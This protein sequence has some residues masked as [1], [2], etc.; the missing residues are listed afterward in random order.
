MG[1]SHEVPSVC[2]PY[3]ITLFDFPWLYQARPCISRNTGSF[4]TTPQVLSEGQ[5]PVFHC[6]ATG[7]PEPSITWLKDGMDIKTGDAMNSYV[8]TR[9]PGGLDLDI[10]YVRKKEHAGRYSCVAKNKFGEQRHEILLAVEGTV[11]IQILYTIECWIWS[12]SI[13]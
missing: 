13:E 3:I 7:W 6:Y 10:L 2:R 4:T 12:I 1:N 5:N 11:G 8:L 9:R